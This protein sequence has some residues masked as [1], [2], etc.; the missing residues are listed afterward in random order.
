MCQIENRLYTLIAVQM[1]YFFLCLVTIHFNIVFKV[2]VY[3][4]VKIDRLYVTLLYMLGF[5]QDNILVIKL[6][7][8]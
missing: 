3:Y 4:F 8:Y 6:M 2:N 5:I 7:I 1:A